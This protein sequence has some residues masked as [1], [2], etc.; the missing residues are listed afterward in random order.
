MPEDHVQVAVIGAGPAGYP[1]AFRAADLGL[2]VALIDQRPEPGGVCLHEGCIPS[3]ALLH[4]ADA[5]I[6]ARDAKAIGI[7]FDPPRIDLS[8]LRAWKTG[9]VK[10]LTGGLAVLCRKRGVR[11][12]RGRAR[13]ADSRTLEITSAPDAPPARLSFDHAIVAT[14]SLPARPKG[15]DL[16]GDRVLD[17]ARALELVDVPQRLLV[18]GGGYI[19][20]ELGSVYAALGSEVTIVEMMPSLLPGA[21]PDLVRL[22]ARRTAGLF[23]A[24][25]LKAKVVGAVEQADGVRVSIQAEHGEVS[26]QVFDRVLMAVGRKPDTTDLGLDR[27]GI[28][29]GEGGFIAVDAQRRTTEP[30]IFAVGD[31]AGEPMLA[32]KGTHEGLVAAEVIAGSKRTFQPRS[33]PAVVFTDPEIAWCGLT[34]SE[35]RTAGLDY[36]VAKFPWAASGRALTMARPEG[37][38]KLVLEKGSERVLGVAL[39]GRGAG[40]MIAE[41]ALAVEM[42][43]CASDLSLTIHPHPTLSET[44]ME[45]A[46]VFLGRATHVYR[47]R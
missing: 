22:L 41:G 36:A 10:Q 3:K 21:D 1:A 12:I 34:E 47:P 8:A 44:V 31:V 28:R 23:K 30:A 19:G 14:G 26:Q 20:L 33:I 15:L 43:A 17:A 7:T 24:V 11:Y 2:Q 4:A 25:H 18:I 45:A 46:E 37:L 5:V 9:V 6:S 16:A 27:T 39:A 13:F 32:H 40:E 38:T 29:I 42:G 35:A